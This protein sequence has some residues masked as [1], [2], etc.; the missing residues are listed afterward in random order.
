MLIFP[1]AATVIS[2]L[3]SWSLFRAYGRT[4]RLQS[5]AWGVSL[6]MYAVASAM[7][8][9]ADVYGWGGISYRLFWLFGA[10]L[11]VPWL[12]A[13]SFALA[14][15]K[16]ARVGI[17]VVAVASALMIG[18]TLAADPDTA[19]LALEDGIPRGK[20]IWPAGSNMLS[21][22]RWASIGGWLIVV[23]IAL[24]TSRSRGGMRPSKDRRL[25]NTLIVIGVSIVAVGGFALG[26]LGG[27]AAFSATLAMGVAFMYAGFRAAS[28]AP[29]F[30]VTDPGEQST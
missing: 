6:A 19:L 7:L 23:G 5:F 25:G 26:R 24:W 29:R 2:A 3:F 18:A 27:T 28:R 30:E 8:L 4:K 14:F 11:N 20:E 13:G 17:A 15:P 12:A 21:M 10:L 1:A 16:L 22:V 9:L